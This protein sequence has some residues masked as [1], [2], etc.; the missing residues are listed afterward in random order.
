MPTTVNVPGRGTL[1][2]DD[3]VSDAEIQ[4]IVQKEFPVNGEDV[5]RSIS[6]DPS[7][8]QRMS[9]DDFMQMRRYK[10]DNPIDFST[11]L[12]DAFGGIGELVSNAFTTA[13]KFDQY[14]GPIEKVV[15][16]GAN[17]GQGAMVGAGDFAN[18]FLGMVEGYSN[19]NNSY[20]RYRISNDLKDTPENKAAYDQIIDKDFE[21]FKALQNWQQQRKNILGQASMPAMAETI[22]LVA[23]PPLSP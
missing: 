16:V 23:Q 18:M 6:E 8:A 1:T 4:Q 5:V 21:G 17:I 15:S 9:R 20:T 19:D 7:Y 2:F 3:N 12:A 14:A 10:D 13:P 11:K 22:S